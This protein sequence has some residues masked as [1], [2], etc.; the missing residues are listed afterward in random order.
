MAGEAGLEHCTSEAG[1]QR[2]AVELLPSVNRAYAQFAAFIPHVRRLRTDKLAKQPDLS[3]SRTRRDWPRGRDDP[4]APP[5]PGILVRMVGKPEVVLLGNSGTIALNT[6]SILARAAHGSAVTVLLLGSFDTEIEKRM[7][8]LFSTSEVH[9]RDR[10]DYWHSVA[11]K[12]LI[13]HDSQPECRHIFH[14]EL[15]AEALAEVGLILFEN[16]AMAVAVTRQHCTRLEAD[17]L[18]VCRQVTGVLVLKQAGREVVLEPGDM[19]LLDPRIPYVGKFS[20]GSNML[21]LKVPRRALEARVGKTAEMIMRSMKPT[22]AEHSLTS[23][24]LAMLPAHAGQLAPA[25]REMIKDQT[26]DLVALSLAQAQERPRPYLSSARAC[27]LL[28]VRAAIEARLTDPSLDAETVAAA[29][30]VSVRYAN[31]LLAQEDTSIVRLIQSRR[32]ERCHRAL[33]DP[34]QAHRTVSEIASAWAFVD[35][36]HF[37]RRFKAAYGILP[38]ELRRSAKQT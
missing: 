10:F 1:T 25:A 33:Q 16:S 19:T 5:V 9:P 32:L 7:E 6:G 34:L 3:A 24:F 37:G 27:A 22:E 18:F 17:E 15:Q 4:E 14:A 20:A 11:C 29:A 2:S 13:V 28:N 21:V 35:M 8:R 31:A 36:T 30:G 12:N 23:A 38:S 26:L